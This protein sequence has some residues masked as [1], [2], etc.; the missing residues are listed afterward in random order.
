MRKEGPDA[1]EG[2]TEPS[3]GGRW[4]LPLSSHPLWVTP[5]LSAACAVS[6]LGAG[7]AQ[8]SEQAPEWEAV[9]GLEV[10]PQALGTQAAGALRASVPTFVGLAKK[11]HRHSF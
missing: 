1:G 11:P 2:A 3:P 8:G 10:T 4:H 6:T 9:R 5:W 7:G